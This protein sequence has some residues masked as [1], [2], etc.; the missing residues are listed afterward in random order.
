MPEASPSLRS[1]YLTA[2]TLATLAAFYG[3][4]GLEPAPIIDL[5]I[6]YGP[7]VSIALW[8]EH[9]ARVRRLA[10]ISDWGFYALFAWPAWLPWY[11]LR[12][13]ARAGWGLLAR[14]GF[15]LLLPSLGGILGGL[16]FEQ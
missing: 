4:T 11:A 1:S 5:G 10:L 3:A 16:W 15:I 13:R 8:L 7:I 6:R 14:L 2:A 9:D 12:S